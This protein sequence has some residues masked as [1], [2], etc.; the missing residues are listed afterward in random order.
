VHS[1]LA[2]PS[3]PSSPSPSRCRPPRGRARARRRDA[4]SA[5]PRAPRGDK[6]EA[7]ASPLALLATFP[8][9]LSRSARLPLQIQ[10][11][12]APASPPFASV[13]P[14]AIPGARR[15]VHRL[16]RPRLRR[17]EPFGGAEEPQRR[18]AAPPPSSR[19]PA[20]TRRIQPLR[21]C[22]E[23]AL[24]GYHRCEPSPSLPASSPR[25]S[26]AVDAAP[27]TPELAV[28]RP[29]RRRGHGDQMVPC[30]PPSHSPR[31]VDPA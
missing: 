19:T 30:A 12:R 25:R 16:R 28:A 4:D 26:R 22:P 21:A 1:A 27:F 13:A 31:R 17:P 8:S 20:R 29:R 7:R 24:N 5:T 6:G 14:T 18:R 11:G 15:A 10:R 9:P 23:Q 3:R 2:Q